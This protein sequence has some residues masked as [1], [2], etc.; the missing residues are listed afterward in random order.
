MAKSPSGSF[1]FNEKMKSFENFDKC[2][3]HSFRGILV[4]FE[5]NHF[6]SDEGE[7]YLANIHRDSSKEVTHNE[8]H[9]SNKSRKTKYHKVIQ[10]M[11]TEYCRIFC[12]VYDISAHISSLLGKYVSTCTFLRKNIEKMTCCKSL[13]CYAVDDVVVGRERVKLAQALYALGDTKKW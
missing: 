12:K 13:E 1:Y 11:Y 3:V 7:L 6:S 9:M 8:I 4:K 5:Q 10:R 2:C